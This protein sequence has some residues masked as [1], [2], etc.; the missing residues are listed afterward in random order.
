MV[1]LWDDTQYLLSV[2]FVQVALV[3]SAF[4]GLLSGVMTSLIVLRHMSFSVHATSELALMGAAAALLFG[5]NIGF[6][7]VAGSIV[8]AIVLAILGMKGQQDSAVGV[9]SA[10]VPRQPYYGDDVVD[11]PDC[12]RVDG[13]TVAA[14]CHHFCGCRRCRAFLAADSFCFGGSR[15][16]ACCGCARA[17]CCDWFRRAAGSGFG[18]VSADR[19]RAFGDGVADHPRCGRGS[20]YVQPDPGS[21]V[22]DPVR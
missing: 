13:L 19:W 12:G 16:G 21:V 18:P 5:L 9:V 11:G 14:G 3:A 22:V 10:L 4:L 7:A 1:Q 8:A 15:Y 17:C 2:D 6:G 20:D